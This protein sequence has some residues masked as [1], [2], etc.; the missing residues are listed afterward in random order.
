MGMVAQRLVEAERR[1]QP[2]KAAADDDDARGPWIS[3]ALVE[4]HLEKRRQSQTDHGD[5]GGKRD[6]AGRRLGQA[7]EG[8]R[9]PDEL[10]RDQKSG[11]RGQK[12]GFHAA[13]ES[14]AL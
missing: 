10:I 4:P 12:K 6:V 5:G 8:S 14:G 3:P 11:R 9:E 2:R 1:I 7:N 13:P